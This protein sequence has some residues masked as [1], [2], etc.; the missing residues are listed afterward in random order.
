MLWYYGPTQ[1][2]AWPEHAWGYEK[3][4][5]TCSKQ[6]TKLAR[7]TPWDSGLNIESGSHALHIS[8]ADLETEGFVVTEALG[9]IDATHDTYCE[10]WLDTSIQHLSGRSYRNLRMLQAHVVQA[11]I[12]V[13]LR[14]LRSTIYRNQ[15]I[16]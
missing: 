5:V 3:C 14:R 12:A 4:L 16:Q 11:S 15:T 13:S 2:C 1:L 6:N 8:L 9:C 7:T 10:Q